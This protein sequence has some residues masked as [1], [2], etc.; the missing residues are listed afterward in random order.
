MVDTTHHALDEEIANEEANA[1]AL[2]EHVQ[3]A[4]NTLDGATRIQ[5]QQLAYLNRLRRR[6]DSINEG[7]DDALVNLCD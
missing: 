7:D 1:A 6:R 3:N 4:R 5:E 2:A